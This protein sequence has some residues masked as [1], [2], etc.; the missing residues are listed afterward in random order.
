MIAQT[1]LYLANGTRDRSQT[2][3]SL[4]HQSCASPASLAFHFESL[5]LGARLVEVV[6][7]VNGEIM[8]F[9]KVAI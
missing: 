5:K 3:S 9:A 1:A 7:Q 2:P 8:I 4:P 6:L